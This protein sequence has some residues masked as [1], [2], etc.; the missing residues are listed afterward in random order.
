MKTTI[1][2]ITSSSAHTYGPT[3]NLKAKEN[4]SFLP[5]INVK[6]PLNYLSDVTLATEYK[7]RF[8][9]SVNTQI[10][11]LQSVLAGH[12]RLSNACRNLFQLTTAGIRTDVG[13]GTDW[14]E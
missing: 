3:A 12:L 2:V 14:C 9:E 7:P 6:A 5:S 10:S 1:V 13:V 11:N 8:P 4:L